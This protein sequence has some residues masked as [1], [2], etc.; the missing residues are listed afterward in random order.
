M[1]RCCQSNTHDSSL[2]LETLTAISARCSIVLDY[3]LQDIYKIFHFRASRTAAASRAACL[4]KVSHMCTL[5]GK[6][7]GRTVI[8]KTLAQTGC[9]FWGYHSQLYPPLS[10]SAF[11]PL[12]PTPLLL[13]LLVTSPANR[14]MTQA[15]GE[16]SGSF[17]LSRQVVLPYH[18]PHPMA[19]V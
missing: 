19:P 12:G 13:G 3:D 16:I 10:S 18:A 1:K 5:R 14:G 7:F 6:A 2:T 4:S 17:W 8:Y 9:C 15:K 11:C